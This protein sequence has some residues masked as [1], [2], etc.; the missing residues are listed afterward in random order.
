[1]ASSIRVDSCILA[2]DGN[3]VS[4]G[5]AVLTI[6]YTDMVGGKSAVKDPR[7]AMV[8]GPGNIDADPCFADA[9]RWDASDTPEDA[10]DD[11]FMPGDY[12]LKSR[13]GRWDAT[14]Q[15]WVQDA[16]T[17]PCVDA[18]NPAL[19]FDSEP[20]PNGS[21]INMGIYGGTAEASKSGAK[22]QFIMTRCR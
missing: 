8:W 4:N 21:R 5:Y 19:A 22:W 6:Q 15:T 13:A 18:G 1:L 11:V 12:H 2:D 3:E 10:N 20:L 14:S 7:R 17:S 16:V 9:G